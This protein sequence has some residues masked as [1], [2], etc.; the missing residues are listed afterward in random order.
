MSSQSAMPKS[1]A[2]TPRRHAEMMKERP[3]MKHD[4]GNAISLEPG[5]TKEIIW[6]FG[7]RG[8]VEIACHLPGHYEAGMRAIVTVAR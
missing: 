6:R 1:N 2:G 8:K 7:K 3:D 4:E 5:E